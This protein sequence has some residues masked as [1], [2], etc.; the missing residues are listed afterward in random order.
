MDLR[1]QLTHCT[2]EQLVEIRD[3]AAVLLAVGPKSSAQ[4]REVYRAPGGAE[5]F[6]R[7]L[8]EALVRELHVRAKVRHMPFENFLTSRTFEAHF[9]AAALAAFEA[10]RAWFPKQSR[11]ERS[12]MVRLYAEL[13]VDGLKAAGKPL[14]WP[15]IAAYVANLHAVVDEAFPGYQAAGMLPKVQQLR[16]KGPSPAV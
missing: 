5:E 7:D 16:V 11:T 10:N 15:V 1:T 8:Y 12:S 2:P 9:K 13:V 4:R 14:V 3:Q 6:T